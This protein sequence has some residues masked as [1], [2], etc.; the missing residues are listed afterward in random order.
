M[1][2]GVAGHTIGNYLHLQVLG[3]STSTLPTWTPTDHR[4]K[5]ES[6]KRRK[7]RFASIAAAI[8]YL[9]V[10]VWS[11]CVSARV[12]YNIFIA[13]YLFCVA[14]KKGKPLAQK[15][16]GHGQ[17]ENRKPKPKPQRTAGC[18]LYTREGTCRLDFR[19]S[20]T[21]YRAAAPHTFTPP[22]P[23]NS[24]PTRTLPFLSFSPFS[25]LSTF[26]LIFSFL[27]SGMLAHHGNGSEGASYASIAL[28]PVLAALTVVGACLLKKREKKREEGNQITVRTDSASACSYM[29]ARFIFLFH[30]HTW[31]SCVRA[32]VTPL[33]PGACTCCSRSAACR[34]RRRPTHR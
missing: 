31:H 8:R 14:E 19:F 17:S 33:S 1:A 10:C 20:H 15:P 26:P 22:I 5:S 16:H 18:T 12:A 34:S 21:G 7:T 11:L 27:C 13:R 25:S 6:E 9:R 30:V 24:L 23:A 29:H 4:Q 2:V 32:P 3:P 28:F